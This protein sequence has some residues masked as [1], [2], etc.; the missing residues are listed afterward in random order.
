MPNGRLAVPE[1]RI[2]Q[3]LPSTIALEACLAVMLACFVWVAVRFPNEA[4]LPKSPGSIAAAASM[5]AGST[6]VGDLRRK[7]VSG[8]GD[9]KAEEWKGAALGWWGVRRE[10]EKVAGGEGDSSEGEEGGG[11]LEGRDRRWGIDVG[12]GVVRGSWKGSEGR[13]ERA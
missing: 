2:K 6:L 12:E 13:A 5:L 8:V 10:E 3:D 7:G 4:V 1:S 11:V 9:V